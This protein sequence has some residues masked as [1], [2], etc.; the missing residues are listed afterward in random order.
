V[1]YS[2]FNYLGPSA[3]NTYAPGQPVTLDDQTGT[4]QY[5]S[6]KFIK[7]YGGPEYRVSSR[8]VLTDN[9]SIKAGYNTQRQYIHMLSNTT[10]MA[11]TDI[12]KL[13]GPHIQPQNGQQLSLGYYRDFKS[14]TIET[15]VEVYYKKLDNYLDYKSGA[16]LVLN[17]HI[18]TDVLTT[19]GKAYGVE[20]LVKKTA[21]KLNG[22]LSYTYSRTFLQQDDPNA[23]QLIN[24]GAYY[25]ANYDRPNVLNFIGNYQINHRFS[26][27]VNVNYSTGRPITLPTAIYDLARVGACPRQH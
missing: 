22:W 3:V 21:G 26:V 11:P 9:V 7:T 1:R 16:S 10:A 8:F 5:P 2:V 17:H 12:W 15:S 18:E 23:G 13:S 6:G 19:R 24:N 20:F 4:V 25:P 14:H 27:S